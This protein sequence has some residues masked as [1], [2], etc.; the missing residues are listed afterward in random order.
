[1]RKLSDM[2]FEAAAKNVHNP[3]KGSTVYLMVKGESKAYAVKVEDV[4]KIKTPYY[5]KGGYD[6]VIK[7]SEN[8]L[9][10]EYIRNSHFGSIEYTDESEQCDTHAVS[11]NGKNQVIYIGVSKEAIK[12][13]VSSK[14][15]DKLTSVLN[16]ITK[17]QE[18]LNELLKEKEKLEGEINLE[19]TESLKS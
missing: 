7:F 4:Q 2:V 6:I 14:A 8:P 9:G 19:I 3:R 16:Q 12:N 5:S 1:M 11:I 17:K 10:V 15:E 13:F 18:E